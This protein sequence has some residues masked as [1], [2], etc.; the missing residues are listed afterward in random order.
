MKEISKDNVIDFVIN[1]VA[2]YAQENN[3][4]LLLNPEPSTRLYGANAGLDSLGLVVFIT[5]LEEAIDEAYGVE[6]T[7]AD[8]K[9]MSQTASPFRSI[10][11]LS[12]YIHK[13]LA[14]TEG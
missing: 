7:L 2:Y 9:A 3:I 13:L 11:S 6:L 5:E 4:R 12:S 10:A 14:V 1:T 8:E